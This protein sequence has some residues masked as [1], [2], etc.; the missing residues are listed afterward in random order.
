MMSKEGRR[1][2]L[3]IYIGTRK[4]VALDGIVGNG[5][6]HVLRW[7][8]IRFPEGFQNGFVTNLERASATIR[9][10]FEDVRTDEEWDGS[11]CYVILGNSKLKSYHF[12]SS[13]YYPN[14]ERN[15]SSS[16]IHSVIE[17]TRSVAT[18]PLS[19]VILQ[20]VPESFLI[21]DMDGVR[22][23]MGLE[24]R[25]LGVH[26]KIFTMNFEEFRNITKAFEASD[27]EV[28]GFFPRMISVSEAVLE[29]Q[30]KDEGV[31]IVDVADDNTQLILWKN[32]YL[33]DS[34]IIGCGA[35]YLTEK[36]A[37][38]WNIEFFDAER[39]K[40]QYGSLNPKQA[41]GEELI[42]LVERNGKGV[43]QIPRGEFL[44]KFNQVAREWLSSI[45][46]ETGVFLRKHNFRYPHYVFTGGGTA[47]DG[48]LEFL[49]N[50]FACEANLGTV[51][52]IE[53]PHEILVD[54]SMCPVLGGLKWLD[55]YEREYR[56]L[57]VPSNIFQ[58]T[59][60]TARDWF[61]TYF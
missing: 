51:H 16:E 33:A 58:K 44:E 25:R 35:R 2:E 7:K 3:F 5:A 12:S 1:R 49:Q 46:D 14:E 31:V 26:L 4:I 56:R 54:P 43:H 48:F 18:L 29:E 40:E 45:I 32:G 61:M 13:Q 34:K 37:G 15:I 10:I 11:S 59:I 42:P 60:A 41:F 50:E 20:V 36:I 28:K 24:A 8:T 23:P 21:N 30:E 17:Q 47:L 22:N 39:V 6:P 19:E 52:R 27:V 9:K 38:L 57:L 53:A 55:R